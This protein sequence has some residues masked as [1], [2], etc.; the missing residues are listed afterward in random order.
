MRGFFKR[1]RSSVGQSIDLSFSAKGFDLLRWA[2]WGMAVVIFVSLGY[3]GW[4]WW[5]SQDL[6]Q[7]AQDYEVAANRLDAANQG[8][9]LQ[10]RQAGIDVSDQRTKNVNREVNF[11]KQLTQ[12]RNFSWTR[13]LSDLEEAVPPR[14]S[15][16]SVTLNFSDS[17]ISVTGS[18]QALKHLTEFVDKLE[19]HGS[20]S[21]VV[22]SQHQLSA[23]DNG[24]A[25]SPADQRTERSPS[26]A[27]DFGMTVG[28]RPSGRGGQGG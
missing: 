14:V 24:Q 20:F 5:D 3:A 9:R 11:L 25:P 22:L 12:K 6:S 15:I 21:N 26:E 18:A 16:S 13:L 27:V 23:K 1:R 7:Q 19:Q 8:Y 10:A 2:Q 4:L 17:R 28:Y